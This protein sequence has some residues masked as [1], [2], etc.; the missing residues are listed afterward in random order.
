[1]QWQWDQFAQDKSIA[2]KELLPIIFAAALWG[3]EWRGWCVLCRCDNQAVVAV[4]NTRSSHDKDIMH[5]LRVLFFIEANFDFMTKAVHI[6]GAENKIADDIS[7]NH[8][9]SLSCQVLTTTPTPIPEELINL[10]I[11]QQPDWT[12]NAWTRMF[13]SIFNKD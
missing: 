3:K 9:I 11:R 7:R 5:L 1:M 10:L 4:I 6:P 2:V 13:S 8:S 12:C